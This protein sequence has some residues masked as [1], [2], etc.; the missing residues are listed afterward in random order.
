MKPDTTNMLRAFRFDACAYPYPL[1][2][3]DPTPI[4]LRATRIEPGP[5]QSHLRVQRRGFW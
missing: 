4:R 5:T 1:E 3:E 2:S